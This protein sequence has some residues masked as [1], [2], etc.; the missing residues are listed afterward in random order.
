MAAAE[1]GPQQVPN[2]YALILSLLR[3]QPLI[4]DTFRAGFREASEVAAESCS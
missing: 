4:L 2:K 3:R 1:P